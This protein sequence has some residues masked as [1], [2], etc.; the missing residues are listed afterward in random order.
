LSAAV[1]PIFVGSALSYAKLGLISLYLIICC[2]LSALF[3]QVATNLFN[4]AEDFKKGADTTTRLGPQRGTQ[5]GMLSYMQVSIGAIICLLLATLFGV[6]LVISGG[7]PI[8]V[9]GLVSLF[10]AYAYT[11]GPA[12]LAYVGLGDIF[13]LIFFGLIA[14]GG[15]YYIQSGQ[16]DLGAFIAG[17]QAGSLATVL[18]VVNNMRDHVQDK[19]VGKMTL[20]ARFGLKFSYYEVCALYALPYILLAYWFFE[21]FYIASLAPL[22]TIIFA[23]KL[24][25]KIKQ[26]KPSSHYNI[27]LASSSKIFL[28]YSLLFSIG[29]VID[30]TFKY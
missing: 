15:V 14:V 26:T 20:A 27:F 23:Y 6:P 4:D 1:V 5:S 2:L 24:V 18:I 7:M 9:I 30:V 17:L 10:F 25:K 19:I 12:P 16:Y 8:V 11:G 29:L 13:V 3:I 28:M 22:I 21:G